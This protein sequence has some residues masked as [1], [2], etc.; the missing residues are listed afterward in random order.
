MAYFLQTAYLKNME[1]D[2]IE[3]HQ[4]IDRSDIERIKSALSE[5]DSKMVNADGVSLKPSQCY[6]FGLDPLH[7]LFNTNCPDE[8]RQKVQD[9][10]SSHMAGA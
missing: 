4:K 9:I 6:H 2:R 3:F 10:I 8:L 5:L 7:V 1:K